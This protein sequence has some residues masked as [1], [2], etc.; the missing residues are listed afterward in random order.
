MGEFMD[1]MED[2]MSWFEPKIMLSEMRDILKVAWSHPDEAVPVARLGPDIEAL[3]ELTRFLN[4]PRR[5]VQMQQ[6]MRVMYGFGDA[7]GTGFGSTIRKSNGKIEWKSGVWSRTMVEEH[8][9]NLFELGNIVFALEDLH[10]KGELDGHEIFMFTDNATAEAAHFHGTSKT[11]KALF[12][13][14]LRLRIIEMQGNCR[15]VMV[16]VAGKRMIWQGSN[17][18][19]WG[20][21]NA[22]VMNGEEMM[23][24]VP[25]HKSVIQRSPKLLNWMW[26]WL[27]DKSGK[28][29]VSLLQPEDWPSAHAQGGMYVWTPPPA[30]AEVALKWLGQSI[31]KRPYNTHDILLP[32]LMTLWWRKKLLKTSDVAFTIPIGSEIRATANHEPLI[33]AVCFPLSRLLDGPWK[34]GDSTLAKQ[35]QRQLPKM[36]ASG[37]GNTGH[38]LRKCVVKARTLSAM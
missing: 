30:A 13:L 20:D 33:C 35:L 11:G 7:S 3:K 37:V 12:E 22:G 21:E 27:G 17:G 28:H 34:F 38:L 36:L 5:R 16:H 9:S 29:K 14:V 6:K 19:S 24:F 32:R 18:L 10:D 26:S 31:H 15:I 25:L 2:D 1:L 8:N 23:S 4:P